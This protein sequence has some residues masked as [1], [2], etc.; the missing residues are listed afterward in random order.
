M[1]FI[2]Y[3]KPLMQWLHYH[4]QLAALITFLIAMGESLA[5]FG[6]IVPG[7]VIMSAIGTLIGAGIIPGL[8]IT[9]W[10]IAG[11]ITGD[12]LS[13]YAGYR[14]THN[15]RTIWPFS[16]YPQWIAKAEDFF[17]KHGSKSV[18]LGRFVG[19]MRP[20]VPVVA[21]MM[22]LK[23]IKF[24][25]SCVV[26]SALWA[27]IYMLPGILIGTASQELAPDTATRFVATILLLLFT[28]VFTAWLFRWLIGKL[29]QQI[30][31]LMAYLWQHLYI[32]SK[33][34]WIKRWLTD[35]TDPL[36]HSQLNRAV[37]TVFF[38]LLM[39]LLILDIT[40]HGLFYHLNKPAHQLFLNIHNVTVTKLAVCITFLGYKF[41]IGPMVLVLVGWM[42]LQRYWRAGLH[43]LG[44]VV[45]AGGVVFITE[46]LVTSPKPDGL[47]YNLSG[48]SFPSSHTT[49][50]VA[51]YGFLAVLI[52]KHFAAPQMKRHMYWVAALVCLAVMLSR[53]Y[54]GADWLTDVLAGAVIGLFAVVITSFSFFHRP[55][56]RIQLPGLLVLALLSLGLTMTWQITHN[57][58][59]MVQVFT[60]YWPKYTATEA[61][62]WE[63]RN[64]TAPLF[65]PN[66]LGHPVQTMN[67]QWAGQ[68]SDI[69]NIFTN[70]GWH[71]IPK[72]DLI[73]LVN[74]VS[75]HDKENV[76][77]YC[78]HFI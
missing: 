22:R 65:R 77:R 26:A 11:A 39:L 50:S 35:P 73:D 2:D 21:G 16:R 15:I 45:V 48:N 58:R 70:N 59:E 75:S 74:R 69:E 4:P 13:Y 52:A 5:F 43:L 24:F 49:F 47:L 1:E 54:L 25:L 56:P 33:H 29:L 23:P 9:L 55:S 3:L 36:S 64:V 57:Y 12:S 32:N 41:V 76:F 8:S 63:G 27:P 19:P 53:I 44:V 38:V 28:L 14:Y 7:S 71:P 34:Y 18:F 31:R 10:A 68:I 72:L 46:L 30:N 42:F 66:R 62:W 37:L 78:H 61:A 17:A 6:L 60:P 20:I 51:I 40:Q 67:I